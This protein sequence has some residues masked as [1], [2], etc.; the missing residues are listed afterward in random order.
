VIL[1]SSIQWQNNRTLFLNTIQF[2]KILFRDTILKKNYA[3]PS[4]LFFNE[5]SA[6]FVPNQIENSAFLNSKP[7]T[8]PL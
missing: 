6:G 1:L 5:A 4:I 3:F 2:F 7:G 8:I